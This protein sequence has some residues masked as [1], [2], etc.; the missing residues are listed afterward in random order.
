MVS[1]KKHYRVSGIDTHFSK[2]CIG[3]ID[4]VVVWY[5]H[6]CQVYSVVANVIALL[7]ANL[8]NKLSMSLIRKTLWL[9][10][11]E[12]VSSKQGRRQTDPIW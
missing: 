3:S 2:Y 1:V 7:C 5:C 4:I 11:R 9:M 8:A 6:Q 12:Y 10:I